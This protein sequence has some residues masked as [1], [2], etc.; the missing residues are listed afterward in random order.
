VS[1]PLLE[2][3]G[4]T[5][6]AGRGPDGRTIVDAVDLTVERGEIVAI[7][8]ESGCGK[9]VTMLS[10]LGALP[11]GLSMTV[12]RLHFDG[13]P[14][15]TPRER[16]A[17]GAERKMALIP[18]DVGSSL[19]PLQ[20]VGRQ[21]DDGIKL[22]KGRTPA[23][24]RARALELLERVGL[25]EPERAARAYPFELS[26][27]MQQRAA[28]A[29][30]I[31]PDPLLIVADEPTTA[32]DVTIQAQVLR[33][34]LDVRDERG[35]SI[36]FVTHDMTAVAE[37]CDR[38]VGMYAGQVVESG[39]VAEV[40]NDPRHPYTR[41]LIE[42]VPPLGGEPPERLRTIGGSPP[43]PGSRPA[44]CRFAPRCGLRTWLGE[45]PRCDKEQPALRRQSDGR[46]ARCHFA[47]E[48]VRLDPVR[49]AAGDMR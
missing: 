8:G 43:E 1:D 14:C 41:A 10:I 46:L 26:G 42:A 16:R 32:L 9:T 47:E 11:A 18:A 25:R 2:V 37:I 30:G 31:E 20:R 34:L 36:L 35:C 33:L 17:I 12:D 21:L 39:P 4:L 13:A 28:I 40:G 15:E 22:R 29:L 23:S 38:V 24:R 49:A 27:G 5:V 45:P 48:A 6:T 19:N 7:V 44:G 3:K